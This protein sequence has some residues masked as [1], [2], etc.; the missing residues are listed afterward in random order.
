MKY[1]ALPI[2]CDLSQMTMG[3]AARKCGPSFVYNLYVHERDAVW[4]RQFLKNLG[5]STEHNPLSPY[6]NLLFD[7]ELLTYE[8]YVSANDLSFG[9]RGP[10]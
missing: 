7:N 5:A 6:V 2:G 8:W 3:E 4:V 9:S 1:A 10:T